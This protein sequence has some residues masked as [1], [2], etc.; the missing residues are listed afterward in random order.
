MLNAQLIQSAVNRLIP[1]NE[2]ER[3]KNWQTSPVSEAVRGG[4]VLYERAA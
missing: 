2:F 4:K 1:L 3:R